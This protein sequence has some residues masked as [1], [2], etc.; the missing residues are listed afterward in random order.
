[1]FDANGKLMYDHTWYSTYVA[2]PEV[3]RYGTKPKAEPPP[4]P[5]KKKKPPPPPPPPQ[6]PPPAG[7]NG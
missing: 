6:S 7:P 5:P 3:I 2:E 1:V 4:P